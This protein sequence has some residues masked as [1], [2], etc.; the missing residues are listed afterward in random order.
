MNGS[1]A[2]NASPIRSEKTLSVEI[3]IANDKLR[4]GL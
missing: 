4:G 1:K 3:M 2:A